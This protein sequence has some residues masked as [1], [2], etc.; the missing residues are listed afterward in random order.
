MQQR[1]YFLGGNTAKGFF[2]YYDYLI[3]QEDAA[4]IYCIKGGPGTGKSSLM[5]SI[6]AEA[7]KRGLDTD[8]IHCSSDP[9]SLDGLII[10]KLKT[11]FVDGTSPQAG[12]PLFFFSQF[13][14]RS[15]R[16]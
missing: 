6:A 8:L 4:T 16:G 13:F 14:I 15:R 7:Q 12:V 11:A 3:R 2:S 9:D 5:K 10:P 1:E